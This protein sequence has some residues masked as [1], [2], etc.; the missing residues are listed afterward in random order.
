MVLALPRQ[1]QVCSVCWFPLLCAGPQAWLLVVLDGSSELP[2]EA[3]VPG[4]S[5]QQSPG[6][7][8]MQ[9]GVLSTPGS[10]LRVCGSLG[11]EV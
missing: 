2:P 1:P 6:P 9:A 7:G 4:P 10:S 5:A 8:R 11:K 3:G